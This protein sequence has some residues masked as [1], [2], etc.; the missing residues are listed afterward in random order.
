MDLPTLNAELGAFAPAADLS[1]LASLSL[2]GE[3]LFPVPS[4]LTANPK[5]L[6]YYRLL[7]GFSQKELF[8]KAKL[9]RFKPME[10]KGAMSPAVAEELPD[11]C[12]AFAA[13]ASELLRELGPERFSVEFLD[14]LTLLTVGPQLRGSN[15]TKIGKLANQAVFDLIHSIVAHGIEKETPTRLEIR[16]SSGRKA[17]IAFSPDPDITIVEEARKIVAIEVK[18]GGDKSN[19]WNRLGEAEKSH[20]SAKQKHFVEFW[21][22]HN[23]PDLDLALA[24]EKSPTTN[25]FY[26][27][28]DMVPGS[29]E[30]GRF[31]ADVISRVGIASQ[32]I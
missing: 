7:L 27:L 6:G 4:I 10:E 30:L 16:M 1:D 14:D 20:Q 5:L 2:R 11:L 25:Q 9:G 26:S 17:I 19:I 3:F 8:V 31:R 23:V 28:R 32:P 18:G 24:R 29:E 22:I 15:N 21:T 13:R 12:R